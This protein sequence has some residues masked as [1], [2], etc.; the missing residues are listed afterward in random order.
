[1]WFA[2]ARLRWLLLASLLIQ[3]AVV[4]RDQVGRVAD[5]ELKAC[6]SVTVDQAWAVGDRGL[7][8]ATNDA[9]RTWTIQ[10]Q[11]LES[12][13]N[14]VCFA[15]DQ[16]GWAFGG[17]IEPLTHRSVGVV[18]TTNDSGRNWQTL[19]SRLPRITGAQYIGRDHLL[20]W[21]DWSEYY[22]SALFESI[23]GGA[24][25]SARPTPCSHVQSAALGSDK[26][27]VLV[28]RV[29]KVH[30]SMDG[31][32]FQTIRLP[33]SPFEPIR[34]CKVVQGYWWLGG[35]VG[36]LFR[37][38]D[39][40]Q[41]E[42]IHVPGT[43]SDWS[44]IS[45]KDLAGFNNRLC[46]VGQPGNVVWMTEDTGNTWTVRKMGDSVCN[47]AVSVLNSDVML[48]CGSFATIHS[49]R[50]GGKAWWPQH[51][52]GSR[53]AVLNIASTSASVAWDL[54][55]QVSFES[56]RN[57]AVYVVHDQCFEE[58]SGTRPELASRLETAGKSVQLTWANLSPSAPVGNLESGAR[59]SDL[60]YYGRQTGSNDELAKS[61]LVRQIVQQIRWSR[62]DVL[63]SD[64]TETGTALEAKTGKAVEAAFALASNAEYRIFSESSGIANQSWQ[65]QRIIVRGQKP[66][67]S[68]A[69]T[70]LLK[71]AGLFLGSAKVN[72]H[73]LLEY[74]GSVSIPRDKYTYRAKG[75]KL[76]GVRDPLEG[77]LLDSATQLNDRTKGQTRLPT[78]MSIGSL[79]DWRNILVTE[80]GNPLTPDRVWESKLKSITKDLPSTTVSPVLMEI[81]IESRQAG[82]WHRWQAALD[83]LVEQDQSSPWCEYAYWELMIHSGSEEVRRVLA[84][85]IKQWEDRT[86]QEQ[87]TA[88]MAVQKSSPF[89]NGA[90]DASPVQQVSFATQARRVRNASNK[91]LAEFTRLFSRWPDEFHSRR[92]EP[93]WAWLIAS[94]YRAL[95]Q[96]PD[97]AEGLDLSRNASVFWPMLSNQVNSWQ[98]VRQA[99]QELLKSTPNP[100]IIRSLGL[101]SV[102]PFLDGL[103]NEA[104]WNNAAVFEL[105]DLWSTTKSKTV[106]RITQDDSFVYIHSHSPRLVPAPSAIDK[107]N[108]RDRLKQDVDHIKLRIDLDRD[109]A[110]WF[111]FGWSES[112]ATS[113]ACND[114]LF[115]NPT[116]YVAISGNESAWQAE[117]AIPIDEIAGKCEF[118]KK[119]PSDGAWGVQAMRHVPSI[120]SYSME[121]FVSDRM[122][123]TDWAYV[124]LRP[125]AAGKVP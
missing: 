113:D 62:P 124:A 12:N 24:T 122:C 80:T 108:R 78:I 6:Q 35:D 82:S 64:C 103:A 89:A 53:L 32:E 37:S 95:Q 94:R 74:P 125:P 19:S 7:I 21:G 70:M 123:P 85:Q 107:N 16:Q 66:G 9:G 105:R 8:L 49:S 76:N 48:T 112:G 42:R 118:S 36:Q 23:D 34:F 3:S 116:W 69:P 51:Q 100:S 121:P 47:H 58:R 91:D 20:A 45:F 61:D 73:P 13:L 88:S 43:P 106:L 97:A 52:S 65:P 117:I 84:S 68:Y 15:N 110:T 17:A 44:M 5:G 114:M 90:R 46:L 33:V 27:L 22:Q 56:K 26:S 50:N 119:E 41:W 83:L 4:A 29:G 75:A 57:A 98:S 115:W 96:Q 28:D 101:A 81:A 111:E 92:N 2:S 38:M 55:T 14:A 18:L 39:G 63:V 10:N 87:D 72:V 86:F 104:L 93:R 59:P 99:E 120:G 31:L 60:G 109:Y 25:W 77:V 1:M 40:E 71:S 11:R 30:R 67:Q 54:L 102:P 79:L